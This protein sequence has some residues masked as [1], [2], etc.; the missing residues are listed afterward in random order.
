[1]L[2][3]HE[4]RRAIS[5]AHA[6]KPVTQCDDLGAGDPSL[7]ARIR[8]Q[9]G[10]PDRASKGLS[11]TSSVVTLPIRLRRP[12]AATAASAREVDDLLQR[13][14]SDDRPHTDLR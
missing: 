4:P 6:K 13:R 7:T 5:P 9:A 11:R 12:R 3:D 1:M 14:I 8:H 2:S 10:R